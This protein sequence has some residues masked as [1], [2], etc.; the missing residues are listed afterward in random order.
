MNRTVYDTLS[1][2]HSVQLLVVLSESPIIILWQSVTTGARPSDE[3]H[4]LFTLPS[5]IKY[6]LL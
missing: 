1:V 4:A 3:W 6:N 2:H 5:V